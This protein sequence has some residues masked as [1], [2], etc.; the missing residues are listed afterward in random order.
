MDEGE[1]S[2]K[3]TRGTRGMGVL[4]EMDAIRIIIDGTARLPGVGT[5]NLR[6]WTCIR[7]YLIFTNTSGRIQITGLMDPYL[8]QVSIIRTCGCRRSGYSS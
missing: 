2:M 5:W 8:C 7:E 6:I 4:E 3:G 1:E